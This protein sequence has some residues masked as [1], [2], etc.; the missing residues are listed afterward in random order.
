MNKN[1]ASFAVVFFFILVGYHFLTAVNFDNI[2]YVKLAGQVIKVELATTISEHEQ[3]LSSRQKLD[4]TEGMLFVFEQAGHHPFWMKDMKFPIDIIWLNEN[5]KVV[6]IQ[7]DAQPVSYPETFTPSE[8]AQY[9]LE[10]VSGFAD[11]NN[12]KI[13]DEAKSIH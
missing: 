10:V 12:L 5:M 9:V 6:Y 2:K 8:N 13:G 4:E 7:K 11:K 1:L 3:G